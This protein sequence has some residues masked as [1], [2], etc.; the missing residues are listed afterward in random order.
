MENKN[1]PLVSIAI[2]SYN[3]EKTITDTLDSIKSQTYK[4]IELIISDDCSKDNTLNIAKSWIEQ[5]RE[6]FINTIII[7][8]DINTGVTYNCNR[9]YK[10]ANGEFIKD[11]AADDI[12]L[13][14]YTEDC[15]IYCLNNLNV[16]VLYTKINYFTDS[17]NNI[18]NR[19]HDYSFFNLQ[20]TDQQK[21]YLIRYGCPMVPTPSVFYR[22]SF[23]KRINYFDERIPMWEDGPM[24]FKI[25]E[26]MEKL[27]LLDKEDVL[28]RVRNDSLSNHISV[29]HLKSQ[30][31]YYY[32]YCKKYE[33]TFVKKIYHKIKMFIFLHSDISIFFWVAK[34]LY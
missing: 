22:L 17:T 8:S 1:Q 14:N 20:T 11:I 24:T 28:V 32:Y 31:L 16:N 25:I 29:S 9:A 19:K 33:K 13:P 30:A 10:A 2:I 21:E 15:V 3:S 7:E 26:S 4:N 12:L 27:Y 5:N 34:I 18:L 6:R 23:I